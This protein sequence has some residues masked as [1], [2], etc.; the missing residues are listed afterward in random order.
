MKG[1]EMS[2][3]DSLVDAVKARL[4]RARQ[5]S[6]GL[7]VDGQDTAPLRP[8]ASY[9]IELEDLNQ[10]ASRHREKGRESGYHKGWQ[11]GQQSGLLRGRVQRAG[12]D[13]ELISAIVGAVT[14]RL[15]RAS[16]Q[17]EEPVAPQR[18]RREKAE[19]RREALRLI[20]SLRAS[21]SV[22][23]AQVSHGDFNLGESPRG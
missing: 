1:R 18:D 17:F 15:D 22:L 4:A 13:F 8:K 7:F 12:E 5:N 2:N 6:E 16:A 23:I 10:I 20:D 11:D 3:D 21:L 9:S 14:E 19:L